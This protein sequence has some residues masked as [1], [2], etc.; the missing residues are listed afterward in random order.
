MIPV[1]G[2]LMKEF[3]H[4]TLIFIFIVLQVE[5]LKAKAPFVS[6]KVTPKA[7]KKSPFP[8]VAHK[9]QPKESPKDRVKIYK[10]S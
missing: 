6:K 5:V 1:S 10:P 8:A 4:L 7:P 9:V 3:F 2:S